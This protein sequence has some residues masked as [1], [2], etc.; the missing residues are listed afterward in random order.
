MSSTPLIDSA[1]SS[2]QNSEAGMRSHQRAIEN[3]RRSLN[4][5]T[6]KDKETKLRESCEGFE[7]MF[8]QK[9]W[10]GM[11]ASLP[12]DGL[13]Q[14]R[15]EKHWQGM[16]DQELGKSMAKSG[17]IGLADMMVSQLSRNLQSAS[18]VAAGSTARKPMSI[19]P[20]PLLPQTTQSVAETKPATASQMAPAPT[21]AA[22]TGATP[23]IPATGAGAQVAMADIYGG[24]AET[25][26]APLP[27][28]A[29]GATAQAGQTTQ[30]GQTT[31]PVAAPASPEVQ[32]ALANLAAQ[33]GEARAVGVKAAE[34][35]SAM[36]AAAFNN[37]P[38]SPGLVASLG[39][40]GNRSAVIN[41]GISTK[42]DTKA[43]TT[44]LRS[45]IPPSTLRA[46]VSPR[47]NPIGDEPVRARARRTAMQEEP[48]NNAASSL[49]GQ[50]TGLNPAMQNARAA[51]AY[52]SN[53]ANTS[54]YPSAGQNMPTSSLA[55]AAADLMKSQ[56]QPSVKTK[57]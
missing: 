13:T 38:P 24:P 22:A 9:M 47:A 46:R 26:Q 18:E 10:E 43:N 50:T 57:L 40:T 3:N 42:T 16:Y 54:T 15:D 45:E 19:E 51:N 20:V 2:S 7:A 17:G 44:G 34:Q 35:H 36:T 21:L 37:L 4:A 11:R 33:A 28:E 53:F 30:T 14:S 12:K 41:T 8:I 56:V 52:G 27:P 39:S 5:G 25:P 1:I 29:A 49:T 6:A 55:D 31:G 32:A 23:A 48:A